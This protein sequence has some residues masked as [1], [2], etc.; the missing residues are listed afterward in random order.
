[1]VNED[2]NGKEIQ[3]RRVLNIMAVGTALSSSPLT[4]GQV[5]ASSLTK[6]PR[7]EGTWP[8]EDADARATS[9]VPADEAPD[10][11]TLSEYWTAEFK[12]GETLPPVI[13]NSGVIISTG[14]PDITVTRL[15]LDSGKKQWEQVISKYT[16]APPIAGREHV[17][18]GYNHR[19]SSRSNKSGNSQENPNINISESEYRFVDLKA[20]NN[21]I[22]YVTTSGYLG[23]VNP[24]KD[25]TEWRFKIDPP[26]YPTEVAA[27]EQTAFLVTHGTTGDPTCHISGG[28][29]AIDL[30]SGDE[31]WSTKLPTGASEVA[32]TEN[33]VVVGAD[34][35]IYGFDITTGNQLWKLK[36]KTASPD[37][38]IKNDYL[39]MG[40]YR[41]LLVVDW[42]TGEKKWQKQFDSRRISPAVSGDSIFAIGSGRKGTNFDAQI[43]ALD[44]HT[45]DKQADFHLN[46]QR[47]RGPAI[48]DNKLIVSTDSGTVYAFNGA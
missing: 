10:P 41:R 30:S 45:G 40:G 32:V 36:T 13:N 17:Y 43:C 24:G 31:K 7:P 6:K 22:L 23:A 28:I 34:G 11:N 2:E 8:M 19:V 44:L 21:L 48:A 9:S 3:R 33:A 47:L 37:F 1:M 4:A 46:N 18:L 20:I 25:R 29:H 35:A 39:V 16:H 15:G 14:S 12:R 27:T 38:A 42:T 5:R 26:N